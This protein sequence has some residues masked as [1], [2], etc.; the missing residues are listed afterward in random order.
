MELF[1]KEM[2]IE[3]SR[4]MQVE[5]IRSTHRKNNSEEFPQSANNAINKSDE[6]SKLSMLY[7][8]AH[9]AALKNL[10]T[11]DLRQLQTLQ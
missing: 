7:A 5:N 9:Q 3:N 4:K 1:V 2:Q 11:R 8:Q 6:E 10:K